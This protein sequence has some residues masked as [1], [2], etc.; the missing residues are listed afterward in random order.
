MT[1]PSSHISIRNTTYYAP[2]VRRSASAAETDVVTGERRAVFSSWP[3]DWIMEKRKRQYYQMHEFM[4]PKF[5]SNQIDLSILAHFDTQN[6]PGVR[7]AASAKPVGPEDRRARETVLLPTSAV[8]GRWTAVP[9]ALS[10]SRPPCCFWSCCCCCRCLR[11]WKWAN[12]WTDGNELI[13]FRHRE[14]WTTIVMRK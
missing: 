9:V 3:A 1:C 7:R 2:G 10:A 14:M 5:C 11:S 6:A 8:G 12:G 4:R 13:G